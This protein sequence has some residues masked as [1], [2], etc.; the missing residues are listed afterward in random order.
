MAT[1]TTASGDRKLVWDLPTRVFHWALALSFAGAYVLAE[2][3]AARSLHVM[4]G[5]T[6]L[7]LVAFRLVWGLIGSR[8][9][10]FSSFAYGPLSALRYLRDLAQGR[11]RDYPGHN[12]AGSWAIFAMLGLA[13]ATGVTGWL[14][15]H[16]V[17]GEEAF[18]E[19]HEAFA[20]AWLALV[21]LH[22]VAVV[23]SSFAHRRNLVASMITGQVPAAIASTPESAGRPGGRSAPARARW[24]PG[25]LLLLAI[26]GFWAWA[27][28]TGSGAL[29]AG[30]RVEAER[31]DYG[32]DG[33]EDD[34]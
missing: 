22:V 4:F 7:G 2:E 18:E 6:V 25:S 10:R 24:M 28:T 3:D 20:N 27:T 16:D 13:L 17:G 31:G 26:A 11:S 5:Y 12:P 14:N 15:L 29:I 32:H 34:D 23:V 8:A 30:T 19:I 33:H 9:S 1:P 21:V